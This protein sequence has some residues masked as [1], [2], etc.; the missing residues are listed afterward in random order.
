MRWKRCLIKTKGTGEAALTEGADSEDGVLCKAKVSAA[1][2]N[3]FN[4]S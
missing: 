3:E 4:S 1:R 2:G